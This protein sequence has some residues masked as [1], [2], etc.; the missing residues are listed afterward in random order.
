LREACGQQFAVANSDVGDVKSVTCHGE[1]TS[2]AI[3]GMSTHRAKKK[4]TTTMWIENLLDDLEK[5]LFLD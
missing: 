3:R 1:V 4:E 5:I 2:R